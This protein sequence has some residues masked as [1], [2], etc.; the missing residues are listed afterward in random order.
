NESFLID[1]RPMSPFELTLTVQYEAAFEPGRARGVTEEAA[2]LVDIEHDVLRK[3]SEQRDRRLVLPIM[4]E[5]NI[6]LVGA[7][8]VYAVIG[9][10]AAELARQLLDPAV[11]KRSIFPPDERVP[12]G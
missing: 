6:G 8:D 4:Q 12:I 2:I 11:G 5:T 9:D 3:E 1:P 10:T 7:V